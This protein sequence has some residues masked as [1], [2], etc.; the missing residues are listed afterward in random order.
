MEL[1]IFY[2]ASTALMDKKDE[3]NYS[4][5]LNL[6]SVQ[7][8]KLYLCKIIPQEFKHFPACQEN[9]LNVQWDLCEDDDIA[10]RM[11][12]IKHLPVMAHAYASR[13]ADVLWQFMQSEYEDELVVVNDALKQV[14]LG[15][16]VGK[17]SLIH[18]LRNC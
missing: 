5:L 10:I 11:E 8:L 6:A 14:L 2:N 3:E 9:A 16:P 15:Y 4:K 17:Y 12:A 18:T 7:K 13:I 1:E